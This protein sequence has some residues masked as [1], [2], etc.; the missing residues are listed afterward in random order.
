MLLRDFI[1]SRKLRLKTEHE[2]KKS[3]INQFLRFRF[4]LFVTI[5]RPRINLIKMTILFLAEIDNYNVKMG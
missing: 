5:V 4:S 1:N 2:E 3:V